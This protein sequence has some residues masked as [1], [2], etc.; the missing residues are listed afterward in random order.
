MKKI[1]AVFSVE[2]TQKN[3][4][5]FLMAKTKNHRPG[6]S[7]CPFHPLV[8]GHLTSL[9][10]LKGSLNHPKKVTA[11]ITWGFSSSWAVSLTPSTIGIWGFSLG[12]ALRLLV[13][14]QESGF[15]FGCFPLMFFFSGFP[16][17]WH[18]IPG[19][20]EGRWRKGENKGLLYLEKHKKWN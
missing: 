15:D 20:R 11:W 4:S 13:E 17:I 6:D 5:I 14:C 8:G 16:R 9:N 18:D 19:F 7:K 2:T 1:G 12:V 10:P 3:T